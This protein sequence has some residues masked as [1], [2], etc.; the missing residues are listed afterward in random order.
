[1]LTSVFASTC[2]TGTISESSAVEA[3]I[4]KVATTPVSVV[5]YRLV[6]V[7]SPANAAR[8]RSTRDRVTSSPVRVRWRRWGSR[9]PGVALSSAS[10][11]DGIV[12]QLVICSSTSHR[13]ELRGTPAPGGVQVQRRAREQR[14]AQSRQPAGPLMAR[15]QR[16]LLT[17]TEAGHALAAG[18][19]HAGSPRSCG[20]APWASPW[21]R[22]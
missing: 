10:T 13:P 6:M 22:T 18:V 1:M 16:E 15:G 8:R 14:I 9:S 4:A 17:W 19:D 7:A 20:R 3:V 5:P 21:S 11:K 12:G 2:P